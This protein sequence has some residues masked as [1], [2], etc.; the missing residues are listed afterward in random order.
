MWESLGFASPQMRGIDE[1]AE[2]FI[3][4]FRAEME[5]QEKIARLL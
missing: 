2:Q 3:S 4:R 1:R 5:F